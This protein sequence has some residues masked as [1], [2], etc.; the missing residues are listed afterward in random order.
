MFVTRG[1]PAHIRSDNSPEFIA[2]AVQQWLT[3]VGVK[4]LYIT[5]GSSWENGYCESSNGS[6][7]DELFNGEIFYTLAEA[8]IVIE[9]WRRH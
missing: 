7:R 2:N 4:T 5:P 6:M 1:P 3:K 9:A 8:Q